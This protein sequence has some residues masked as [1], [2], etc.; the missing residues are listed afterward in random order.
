MIDFSYYQFENF[1]V[2]VGDKWVG[3]YP[4]IPDEF[5]FRFNVDGKLVPSPQFNVITYDEAPYNRVVIKKNLFGD[6]A[7]AVFGYKRKVK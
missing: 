7:S 3:E 4:L 5:V 6:F 1:M 2:K